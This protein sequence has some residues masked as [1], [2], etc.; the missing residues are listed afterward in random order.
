VGGGL[1]RVVKK[2]GKGKRVKI[3][4]KSD[5]REFKT[6]RHTDAELEGKKLGVLCGPTREGCKKP[7]STKDENFQKKVENGGRKRARSS[8]V[9]NDFWKEKAKNP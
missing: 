3:D 9:S 6:L 7:L 5:T 4:S 2:R 8:P 1:G